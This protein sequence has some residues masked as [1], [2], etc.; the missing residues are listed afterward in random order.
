MN[1]AKEYLLLAPSAL[2][3]P[4]VENRVANLQEELRKNPRE[5]AD[6]SACRDIYNWAQVEQEK[7]RKTRDPERRQTMLEILIASQRGDCGKA[8]T[9]AAAYKGRYGDR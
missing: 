2:D 6:P 5:M 7:A 9:A 8:S 1:H 3:R 4:D